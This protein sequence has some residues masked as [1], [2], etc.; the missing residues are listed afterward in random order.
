[1]PSTVFGWKESDARVCPLK[2]GARESAFG[3]PH[4]RAALRDAACSLA[5][6]TSWLYELGIIKSSELQ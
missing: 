1:M 6:D 4:C 2:R 3:P 5:H